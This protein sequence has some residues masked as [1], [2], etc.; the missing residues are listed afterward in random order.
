MPNNRESESGGATFANTVLV[1]LA[2]SA[3]IVA[4]TAGLGRALHNLQSALTGKPDLAVYLLLPDEDVRNV[5]LLRGGNSRR[6]YL[7]ET[8]DGPKL[9]ILLMQNGEWT[10]AELEPLHGDGREGGADMR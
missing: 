10:V 3:V 5:T 9:A 4:A 8:K 1:A 6:D 2:L 7:V